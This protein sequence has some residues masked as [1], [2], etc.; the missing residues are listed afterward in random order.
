MNLWDRLR[1]L[2][3]ATRKN[4]RKKLAGFLPWAK[5]NQVEVENSCIGDDGNFAL[6]DDG[7]MFITIKVKVDDTNR[8]GFKKFIG[9]MFGKAVNEGVFKDFFGGLWK[10]SK[11]AASK[12]KAGAK[13]G[14]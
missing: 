4:V 7:N 8:K 14:A 13:E 3:N 1:R 6:P 2:H 10:G 11:E 9:G 5:E 12:L